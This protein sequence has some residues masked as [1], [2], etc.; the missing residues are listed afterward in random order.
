DAEVLEPL[1]KELGVLAELLLAFRAARRGPRRR[2]EERHGRQ[3]ERRARVGEPEDLLFR[4]ATVRRAR[5][6][7][8]RPV[9]RGPWPVLAAG[10]TPGGGGPAG[11]GGGR[12]R[13]GRLGERGR[14]GGGARLGDGRRGRCRRRRH[15]GPGRGPARSAEAREPRQAGEERARE[16]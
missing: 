13:V 5:P 11:G 9:R 15:G 7:L 12:G 1:P 4:A 14:R 2:F 3:L 10:G 6:L 16:A 8:A